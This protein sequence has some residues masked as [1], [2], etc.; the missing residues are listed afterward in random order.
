MVW[1]RTWYSPDDEKKAAESLI[2]V[3]VDVIAQHQ[4][5]AGPQE[6][7]EARGIY[8]VGYNADMSAAAPPCAFDRRRMELDRFLSQFY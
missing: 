4:N 6:A 1:T 8:S 3:G 7:A 2:D 5:S